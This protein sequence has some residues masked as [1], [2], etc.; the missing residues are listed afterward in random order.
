[1]PHFLSTGC[2]RSQS[3]LGTKRPFPR[4]DKLDDHVRKVHKAAVP[5]S[6]SSIPLAADIPGNGVPASIHGLDGLD[7]LADT[8]G[9][10]DIDGIAGIGSV[11]G[12]DYVNGFASIDGVSSNGGLSSS[13]GFAMN[14]YDNDHGF[15]GLNEPIDINWLGFDNGLELDDTF[16]NMVSFDNA[17]DNTV[18]FGNSFNTTFTPDNAFN[19][20][21]MFEVDNTLSISNA[22]TFS[23]TDA[24]TSDVFSNV[25][26]LNYI[27]GSTK[28]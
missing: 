5:A 21:S 26:E 23:S 24:F 22:F 25:D 7:S 18:N 4:K 12:V 28:M 1:M 2:D 3:F 10:I 11:T 9:S 6:I 27:D 13:S 16:D 8:S 20:N 17:F 15:A 19:V 14:A